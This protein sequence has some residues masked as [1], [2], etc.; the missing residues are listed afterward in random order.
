[1]TAKKKEKLTKTTVMLPEQLLKEAQLATGEGITQTLRM[2]LQLLAKKKV[3]DEMLKM[4]GTYSFS[5]DLDELRED[6][7]DFT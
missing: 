5:L 3:Y 7:D 4:R 1:M 2:G 6:R